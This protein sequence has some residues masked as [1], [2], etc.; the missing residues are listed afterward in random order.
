[1]NFRLALITV[2]ALLAL[3]GP[4]LA[5]KPS[6]QGEPFVEHVSLNPPAP[7]GVVTLRNTSGS[8]QADKVRLEPESPVL[9]LSLSANVKCVKDKHVEFS[10]AKAYFG[11]AIMAGGSI[12]SS[13]ALHEASYDPSFTVWDGVGNGK[14]NTEAGNGSTFDV[15]LNAV[16]NGPANIAFDPAA[17]FNQRLEE[18]VAKGGNRL[19]F[20]QQPQEFIVARVVSLG[21]W[22]QKDGISRSGVNSVFLKIKVRYPGQPDLLPAVELNGQLGQGMPSQIGQNLPMKL[23]SAT[24]QPNMPDYIGACPPAQDPVIRVN[25]SGSGKG[26]VRFSIEDGSAVYGTEALNFDASNGPAHFDFPYPLK[27]KLANR[28]DWSEPNKTIQ[29]HL[30]IRAKYRDEKSNT[31][32]DWQNYGAGLW[33]HRCTPSLNVV[34]GGMGGIQY[35]A[36]GGQ[37]PNTPT[38]RAPLGSGVPPGKPVLRPAAVPSEPV[39]EPGLLAPTLPKPTRQVAPNRATP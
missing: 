19:T 32:S 6:T 5:L 4:A 16:R 29:H 25:Y 18:H 37:N 26:L 3:Q 39:R 31:W 34:P 36:P 24:F 15:P 35:Q 8:K 7:A 28:P 12:D 11:P 2:S 21:G 38:L 33:I 27:T 1:M 9:N 20:L 10:Q 17:E 13:K 22:C 23:V 14:W 30:T